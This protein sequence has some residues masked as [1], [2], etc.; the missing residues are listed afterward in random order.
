MT[1][2]KKILIVDDIEFNLLLMHELLDGYEVVEARNGKEAIECYKKGGIAMIFMDIQMPVM[3]GITATKKIRKNDKLVPII[4]VTS[5]TDILKKTKSEEA[6]CSYFL[7]K[8]IAFFTIKRMLKNC[9]AD[10][11]LLTDSLLF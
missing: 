4:M 1:I 5:F 2:K 3:D 9:L 10:W 6:G 8:P 7:T 11:L